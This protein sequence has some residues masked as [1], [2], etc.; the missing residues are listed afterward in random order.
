MGCVYDYKT[1][2]AGLTTAR[3]LKIV[4]AWN[5]RFP[6]VP[7]VIIEMRQHLPVWSQ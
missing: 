4:T 6:G 3:V 2:R 7:V 5:I 1:G